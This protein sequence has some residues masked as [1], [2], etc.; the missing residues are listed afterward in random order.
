MCDCIKKVEEFLR[1]TEPT[2]E[3]DNIQAFLDISKK[4]GDPNP[5][6]YKMCGTYTVTSGKSKPK[7]TSKKVAFDYC[8]FCGEAY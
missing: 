7:T 5:Y 8:P 1:K 2:A 3:L 6:T 4:V